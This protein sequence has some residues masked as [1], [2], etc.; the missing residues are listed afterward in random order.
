LNA[1]IEKHG[2]DDRSSV[3]EMF[4]LRGE[5]DRMFDWL[6][7]ALTAG[8][9]GAK[10]LWASPFMTRYRDDPRFAAYCSEAG[11]ATPAEADAANAAYLAKRKQ[12][13]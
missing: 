4:A 9:P 2:T 10:E 5:P 8:D 3:A 13:P 12:Q 1:F 11:I 6:Q 7:R